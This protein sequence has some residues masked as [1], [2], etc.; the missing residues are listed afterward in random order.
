MHETWILIARV[1]AL[2]HDRWRTT[3]GRHRPFAGKIAGLEE[4]VER[5]EAGEQGVISKRA[6]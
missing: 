4:R 5:Q 3:I 1:I 2:A 6:V